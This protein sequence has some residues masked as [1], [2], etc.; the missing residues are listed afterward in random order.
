MLAATVALAVVMGVAGW[1][2]PGPSHETRELRREEAARLNRL[3]VSLGREMLG[4]DLISAS[5]SGQTL[6][7]TVGLAFTEEWDGSM[8]ET[9]R[10]FMANARTIWLAATGD[11]FGT[12]NLYSP[13]RR[14][15]GAATGWGFHCP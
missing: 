9:Q 10:V 15:I 8:C 3:A 7:L 1:F 2:W 14:K 6:S 11:E 12:V 13:T 5:A 4:D